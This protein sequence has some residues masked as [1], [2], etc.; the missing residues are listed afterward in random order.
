VV[1][2]PVGDAAGG[3]AAKTPSAGSGGTNKTSPTHPDTKGSAATT[4]APPPDANWFD[5]SGLGGLLGVGAPPTP[6]SA[7]PA[8]PDSNPAELEVALAS[9]DHHSSSSSVL[10]LG[11][12]LLI[13]LA[14][15]G[16][17]AFRWWDRRPGRYW[18]A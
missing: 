2:G 18:P 6:A 4:A 13:L 11:V 8:A 7:D 12:T 5:A 14:L 17:V 15:G 9:R 16:G 3:G 10:L 1:T